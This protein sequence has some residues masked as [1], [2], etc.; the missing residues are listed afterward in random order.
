ME[1]GLGHRKIKP[2]Y[3]DGRIRFQVR[4]AFNA[5]IQYKSDVSLFPLNKQNLQQYSDDLNQML[6]QEITATIEQS[7]DQFQSDY[8]NF[9]EIFRLAY[10]DEFEQ[11]DWSAEYPKAE[12][13]VGTSVKISVSDKIDIEAS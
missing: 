11:M 13:E 7:Q 10:P 6:A 3:Q 2:S 4:L 9:D 5:T 12:I 8:L 1:V